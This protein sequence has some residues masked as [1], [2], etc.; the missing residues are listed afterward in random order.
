[1]SNRRKGIVALAIV[2]S[3]LGGATAAHANEINPVVG[4]WQ[5]KTGGSSETSQP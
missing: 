1:M 5:L 2:V 3:S 4:K